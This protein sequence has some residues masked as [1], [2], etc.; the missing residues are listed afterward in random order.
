MPTVLT[1]LQL[2]LKTTNESNIS[3]FPL[4]QRGRLAQ[5][6]LLFLS[7]SSLPAIT[8]SHQ[9]ERTSA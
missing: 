7:F 4:P 6:A 8:M 1:N 5:Q 9:N 2:G 3:L